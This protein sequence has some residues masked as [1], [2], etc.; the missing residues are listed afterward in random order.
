MIIVKLT[1]NTVITN[2]FKK[3]Y[4]DW[5]FDYLLFIIIFLNLFLVVTPSQ[6]DEI[7]NINKEEEEEYTQIEPPHLRDEL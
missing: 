2:D 7:S 3:F 5:V 1:L 6:D 4:F